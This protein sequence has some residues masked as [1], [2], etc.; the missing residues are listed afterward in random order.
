MTALHTDAPELY[1]ARLRSQ[2]RDTVRAAMEACAPN[3]RSVWAAVLGITHGLLDRAIARDGDKALHVADALAAPQAV[4]HA[5]AQLLIGDGHVIAALPAADAC[6]DDLSLLAAHVRDAS[7]AQIAL[8]EAMA[9]GVVAADEGARL[10]ATSERLL[11]V[12][13]T[14]RALGQRAVTQRAVRLVA[15]AR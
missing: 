4:R 10:V 15:R 6:Q 2:V 13:A 3:A 14:V 1:R 11:S 8:V 7:A 12:T 5:L 9:D